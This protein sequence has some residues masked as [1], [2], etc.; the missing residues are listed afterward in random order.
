[1]AFTFCGIPAQL[2]EFNLKNQTEGI[3]LVIKWVVDYFTPKETIDKPTNIFESLTNSPVRITD[4]MP[5]ILQHDG[6]SRTII[7]YEIDGCG[8]T[9]LLMFDPA[10]RPSSE[11]RSKAL[12]DFFE[13]HSEDSSVKSPLGPSNLKR[14]LSGDVQFFNKEKSSKIREADNPISSRKEPSMNITFPF[15]QG[16]SKKDGL[17]LYSMLQKFRLDPKRLSKKKQYQI[18]YFPMTAP[19]TDREKM[20]RKQ[21]TSIKI[22]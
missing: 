13:S 17:D 21:V 18:L 12:A 5:L 4:K 9:N 19:L 7:G 22:S 10:Y 1:M 6:H 2:V 14:K 11:L 16:S 15:N 8:V 3:D 20:E